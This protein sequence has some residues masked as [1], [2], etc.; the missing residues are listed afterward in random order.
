M[1]NGN[2]QT[3]VYVLVRHKYYI[4]V[5]PWEDKS[6]AHGIYIWHIHPNQPLAIY[7]QYN[8]ISGQL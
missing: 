3:F 1:E 6:T 7:M 4:I 8:T 5:H 2:T